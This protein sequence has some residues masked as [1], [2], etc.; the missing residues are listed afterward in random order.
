MFTQH[1]LRLSSLGLLWRMQR[2]SCTFEIMIPL[3]FIGKVV[4]SPQNQRDGW[5]VIKK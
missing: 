1:S 2:T 4:G 3:Y 5:W